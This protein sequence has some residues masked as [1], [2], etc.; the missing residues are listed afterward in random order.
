MST[1]CCDYFTS[2]LIRNQ[3]Q[4][5]P[6][7]WKLQVSDME[8]IA[9]R[10]DSSIFAERCSMWLSY[11]Q[12]ENPIRQHK[13]MHVS[14]YFKCHKVNLIRLLYVNYVGNLENKY[15]KCSCRHLGR[16]VNVNHYFSR[17][18]MKPVIRVKRVYM[19]KPKPNFTQIIR[20]TTF[21]INFS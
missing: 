19:P 8:R 14:F 12:N 7:E 17:D 2:E 21:N 4:T 13:G 10:I 20:P 3:L 16:C 6:D 11:V 18:Y 15:I 5:V 1:S 9:C